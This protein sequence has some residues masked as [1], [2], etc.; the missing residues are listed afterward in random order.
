MRHDT[1]EEYLKN[2]WADEYTRVFI[3]RV[4]FQFES[5]YVTADHRSVY[6]KAVAPLVLV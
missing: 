1:H 2:E 4:P 3:T 5:F 6:C